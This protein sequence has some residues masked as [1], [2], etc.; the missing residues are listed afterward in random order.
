MSKVDENIDKQ[1]SDFPPKRKRQK[2]TRSL[3]KQKWNQLV[4]DLMQVGAEFI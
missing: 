3:M 2:K 4:E 1:E